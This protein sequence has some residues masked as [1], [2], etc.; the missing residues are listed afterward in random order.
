MPEWEYLPTDSLY[1]IDFQFLSLLINN[2]EFID[3]TIVKG[4]YLDNKSQIIFDIICEEYKLTHDLIIQKLSTYQN[5][6]VD[7]FTDLLAYD[8]FCA[9]KNIAFNELE[10]LIIERYKKNQAETLL[11]TF[12]GDVSNL[13]K[14]LNDLNELDIHENDYITYNDLVETLSKKETKIKLGYENLDKTLNLS[15]GDFLILGAGTGTGKTAFAI[16]LLSKLSFQ[17]QC[18]YI[19]MEMSKSVLYKRL[20]ACETNITLQELNNI[21]DLPI[22]KK[23]KLSDA[24]KIIDERKIILINKRM[25]TKEINKAILSVKTDKHIVVIV[26]HIGLIVS[27]GNSIYEKMTNVALDLRGISK[28]YDCT[29]I[30]LAQLSRGSQKDNTIPKLQD[31]R[32][33]GEVEQ[34]ARKVILLYNATDDVT[35]RYHDMKVIVAKN[36]DGDKR[37]VDMVFDRYTQSFMERD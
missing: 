30:G 24:M 21:G 23:H 20:L 5:F 26:D 25:N 12:D 7:Y 9:N 8:V 18:V 35:K 22:E 32:D 17:Y 4:E 28:N 6:N 3:K 19:N 2:I 37:N 14:N 29:M 36:D 13:I 27:R 1:T 34:S 15:Q 31:L 16:N 10:K 33:S 11:K